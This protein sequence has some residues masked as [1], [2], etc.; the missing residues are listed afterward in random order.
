MRKFID[1]VAEDC[2]QESKIRKGTWTEWQDRDGIYVIRPSSNSVY[3]GFCDQTEAEIFAK[4]LGEPWKVLRHG[5]YKT[6]TD[7]EAMQDPELRHRR[8]MYGFHV[9]PLSEAEILAPLSSEEIE[10]DFDDEIDPD[11]E[12]AKRVEKHVKEVCYKQFGWEMDGGYSVMFD[13]D[14]DEISI[15]VDD[16]VT[17]DHLKQLTVLGDAVKVTGSS[18]YR[19]IITIA[20]HKGLDVPH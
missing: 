13:T 9:D 14:N 6:M 19:V 12:R 16:E 15:T 8:I 18:N 4:E 5:R 7:E 2:T 3:V 11:W 10:D 1:I 20:V 17:L